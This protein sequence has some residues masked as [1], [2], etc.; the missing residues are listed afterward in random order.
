VSRP[1]G[2]GGAGAPPV[3]CAHPAA[4]LRAA[5]PGSRVIT[6]T[7]AQPRHARL[8]AAVALAGTASLA[9]GAGSRLDTV[10]QRRALYR[11]RTGV[12]PAPVLHAT[13][14]PPAAGPRVAG[15][16]PGALG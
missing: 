10:A 8:A 4:G 5:V 2:H 15:L 7:A 3:T 12:C 11:S 16:A 1:P 9:P 13:V 14:P 6:G